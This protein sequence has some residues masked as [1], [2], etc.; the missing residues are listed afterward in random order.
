SLHLPDVA[1]LTI[2]DPRG[3]WV[4]DDRLAPGRSVTI[5][6]RVGQSQHS[7]FDGEVV[8]LEPDYVPGKQRLVVRAFD[9]LHRLARGQHVRSFQ[10]VTDGDIIQ[11]IGNEVGLQCE[12]SEANEVYPYV[13][14]DNETNLEFLRDRATSL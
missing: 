5:A 13:L 4:D 14:Q 9:R 10:N 1:S 7:I 8:E 2:N 6:T 3:A 11:T 12:V